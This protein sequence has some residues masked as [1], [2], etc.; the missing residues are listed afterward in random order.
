ML[1]YQN[2][3]ITLC[4]AGEWKE[5][6]QVTAVNASLFIF[7][8]PKVKSL[9][10]YCMQHLYAFKS[11]KTSFV[12]CFIPEARGNKIREQRVQAGCINL[13]FM[14]QLV[15]CA[16]EW[17]MESFGFGMHKHLYDTRICFRSKNIRA[18]QDE[19]KCPVRTWEAST[20]FPAVTSGRCQRKNTGKG[21]DIV[22]LIVIQW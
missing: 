16:L 18:V 5:S 22:I 14:E 19:I 9:C 4:W 10:I 6:L 2:C 11:V 15:S 13:W 1:R 3:D 8:S 7:D 21:Q 17:K 20:L 12:S